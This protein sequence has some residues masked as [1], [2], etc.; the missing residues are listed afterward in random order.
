L[1]SN[2]NWNNKFAFLADA[3]GSHNDN[4]RVPDDDDSDD[5][6]YQYGHHVVPSSMLVDDDDDEAPS[7]LSCSVPINIP[8]TQALIMRRLERT[9]SANSEEEKVRFVE[10]KNK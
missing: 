3:H 9:V 8:E 10:C 6:E 1:G 4:K 5:G 2:F 7:V